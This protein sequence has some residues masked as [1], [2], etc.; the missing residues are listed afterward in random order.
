MTEEQK[1]RHAIRK[2]THSKSETVAIPPEPVIIKKASVPA[3]QKKGAKIFMVGDYHV[4]GTLIVKRGYW[5]VSAR[6]PLPPDGK[7]SQLSRSTGVKVQ[8]SPSGAVRQSREAQRIMSKIVLEMQDELLGKWRFRQPKSDAT[9]EYYIDKALTQKEQDVE[10]TTVQAYRGYAKSLIIPAFKNVK[11]QDLNRAMIQDFFNS[12]SIGRKANTLSKYRVVLNMA[13]DAAIQDNVISISPMIGVKLPKGTRFEG[14]RYT[15]KEAQTIM[16]L[17]EEDFVLQPA[18]TL[19]LNLGLRRGEICGL[20]WCDVDFNKDEIRIFHTVKQNG[21]TVYEK[22]HT[23]TKSSNR[24]IPLLPAMVKYLQELQIRQKASGLL[25]DKVCAMPNGNT[26]QPNYLTRTWN[27]FV[28]KHHIRKVRFH[29]LRHTAASL[30]IEN[31]AEV[32]SVSKILGHSSVAVTLDVY[33]HIAQP[34]QVAAL[35]ALGQATG[36]IP[37]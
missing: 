22:E 2:E 24:V 26:V 19:A 10:R 27:A 29:D 14:E 7:V 34:Q 31:G 37:Q 18:V 4:K 28:E 23:K 1:I 15:A 8:H 30:M 36:M 21:S 5:Y 25:T 11:I 6:I 17:L 3:H 12:V 13:I 32:K 33:T 20:R 9:V 16:G 35:E